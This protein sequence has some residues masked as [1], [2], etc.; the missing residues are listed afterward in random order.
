MVVYFMNGHRERGGG[1]GGKR[2]THTETETERV[3]GDGTA[4][5]M[6]KTINRVTNACHLPQSTAVPT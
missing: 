2:D 1:R 5:W 6:L 3:D 4:K